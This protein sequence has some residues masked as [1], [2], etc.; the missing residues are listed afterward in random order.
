MESFLCLVDFATCRDRSVLG[1]NVQ[2][3]DGKHV[4]L[5]TLA[6]R[7]LTEQ[8]TADYISS[9]VQGVLCEYKVDLKQVQGSKY[10]PKI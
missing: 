3:A 1:I 6:V 2:Y 8:H 4:V 10:A 7:K 9:I 5:R